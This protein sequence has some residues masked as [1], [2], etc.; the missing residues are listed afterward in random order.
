MEIQRLELIFNRLDNSTR[1]RIR[2]M[3]SSPESHKDSTKLEK[4]ENLVRL[5]IILLRSH[6]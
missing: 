1:S 5:E 3:R 2:R 4:V 6:E